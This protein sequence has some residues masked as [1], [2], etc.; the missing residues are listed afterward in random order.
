MEYIGYMEKSAIGYLFVVLIGLTIGSFLNVV[1]HR[2][3][4]M[5][6]R[7]WKD[8]AFDVLEI[9]RAMDECYDLAWPASHCPKCRHS[10]SAWENIPLLSWLMLK[11]RG[12]QVV[13]RHGCVVGNRIVAMGCITDCP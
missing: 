13:C 12:L 4:R 5:M 3:P 11:E 7:R 8:M 9:P 2:L 6:E 1:I 10:L